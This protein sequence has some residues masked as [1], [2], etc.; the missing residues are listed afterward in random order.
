[1]QTEQ[2][3]TYTIDLSGIEEHIQVFISL[4]TLK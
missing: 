2:D 4:S 3:V 1:M